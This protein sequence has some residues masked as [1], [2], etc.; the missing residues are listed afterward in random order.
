MPREIRSCLPP[1]IFHITSRGA[2]RRAIFL[3]D[4]DR[5]SF[6]RILGNTVFRFRWICLAYC[7]M[8]T[9]YHLLI[10]TSAERLSGGMNYLNG[11][12]LRNYNLSH[13]RSGSLL[14]HRYDSKSV[15]TEYK[16]LNAVR[17]LAN[18]PVEA[19][20]CRDPGSWKWS[21]YRSTA[22]IVPL[23]DFLDPTGI[24]RL[25]S[26]DIIQAQ[27]SYI[28]FVEGRSCEITS[29]ARSTFYTPK[30]LGTEARRTGIRPALSK[31][32]ED[33]DSMESRNEAISSAYLD[34]GYTLKEIAETV[35]LHES[36]ICRI[37]RCSLKRR[38]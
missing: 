37:A 28:D 14:E 18:N 31:I 12:Y 20:M 32:F 23:P 15:D 5:T 11:M 19:Q 34:Y 2:G 13:R 10:D 36:S 29:W 35:G 6:L 16:L 8:T 27:N 24:Y 38:R 25:F 33:C 21:S 3:D 4:S 7:E 30:P 26:G 1:G 9:H 17:Y 22:G